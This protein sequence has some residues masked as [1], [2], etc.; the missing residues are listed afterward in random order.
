MHLPLQIGAPDVAFPRL[1]ALAYWLFLFG[2]LIVVSGFLTPGGAADFG[3]TAYPPLSDA[4]H[5]PGVGADL[6]IMGLAVVRSG[7]D[8][9]RGQHDHHG[10]LLRAPGDDDV[11]DA[12]LHLEHPG[13]RRSWS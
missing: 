11:P 13:H 6:W 10:R 12:D 3:W 1:N 9:R 8:P 2:A 7:H 5:S 4:E